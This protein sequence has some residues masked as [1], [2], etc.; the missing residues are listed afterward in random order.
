MS[1]DRVALSGFRIH[2][3]TMLDLGALTVLFGPNGAGKTS[4][5][6]AIGYLHLVIS[7]DRNIADRRYGDLATNLSRNWPDGTASMLQVLKGDAIY[8]LY[9]VR[10]GSHVVW[11]E[12]AGLKSG[13]HPSV[14]FTRNDRSVFFFENGTPEVPPQVVI[15]DE[16]SVWGMYLA[17]KATDVNGMMLHDAILSVRQ[18]RCREFSF[19]VIRQGI[20]KSSADRSLN[21]SGENLWSLLRN[22]KGRSNTERYAERIQYFLRRAFP[23]FKRFELEQVSDRLI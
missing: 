1:I 12:D 8:R 3:E 5:F 13:I 9:P 7:R 23:S 18:Y 2:K 10:F 14:L 16:R 22:L 15:D 6:D 20:S 21:R 11:N 17:R 19:D 4:L